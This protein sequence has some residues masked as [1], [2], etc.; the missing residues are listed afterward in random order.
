[1][2]F[3]PDGLWLA[4]GGSDRTVRVWDLTS[5]QPP[6]VL[7]GHIGRVQTLAFSRDGRS[8]CSGSSDATAL[9]WDLSGA[10]EARH[11]RSRLSQAELDR[12][13]GDLSANDPAR[14]FR[15]VG[16]LV[17]AGEQA[18]TL[19]QKRR[20]PALRLGRKEMAR[21]LADLSDD[22]F[23]VREAATEQLQRLG[24]EGVSTMRTT[25]AGELP[26]EARRRIERVIEGMDHGPFVLGA[27]QRVQVRVTQVLEQVGSAEARRLLR[28]YS[29]GSPD[30]RL[31]REAKA[32]LTRLAGRPDTLP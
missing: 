24:P 10:V 4:S 8:L 29:K 16:T 23:A 27:E 12:L 11:T 6:L 19:L 31:T 13:W 5:R 17:T 21:L 28:A 32:S 18:V 15:A 7:D 30:A 3:S 1:V 26:L 14:A 20:P 25:L 22:S 2:A 9:L